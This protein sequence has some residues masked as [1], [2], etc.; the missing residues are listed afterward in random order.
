M[1]EAAALAESHVTGSMHGMA[2]WH[3]IMAAVEREPGVWVMVA[4][5]GEEYGR[6]EIRRTPDG[7]RYRAEAPIGTQIGW[8]TSLRQ[9]C[10]RVHHVFLAAHVPGI[11]T[12][13]DR[14]RHAESSGRPGS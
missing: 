8:G 11:P 13:M 9:A 6:V 10:E 14:G 12:S 5:L 4:P 1:H 3:P 7:I 2:E